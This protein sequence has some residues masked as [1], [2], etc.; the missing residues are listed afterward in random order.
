MFV[1]CLNKATSQLEKFSQFFNWNFYFFF[2][3]Y[4][5]IMD[6]EFINNFWFGYSGFKIFGDFF[7]LYNEP[8]SHKFKIYLLL[9]SKSV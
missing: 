1:Y 6:V 5:Y 4:I 3:C 2:Q 7:S 8:T 9:Y